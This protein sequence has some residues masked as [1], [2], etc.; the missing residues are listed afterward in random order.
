VSALYSQR[1][2]RAE[3][4]HDY[5]GTVTSCQLNRRLTA[6]TLTVRW[7]TA[8]R[9]A[10]ALRAVAQPQLRRVRVAPGCYETTARVKLVATGTFDAAV[11]AARLGRMVRSRL[12]ATLENFVLPSCVFGGATGSLSTIATSVSAGA[13]GTS[14]TELLRGDQL[15][16]IWGAND[17]LGAVAARGERSRVTFSESA[18]D[19]PT[20]TVS[21]TFGLTLTGGG[22]FTPASDLEHATLDF[23][24]PL[25]QGTLT[26]TAGIGCPPTIR[27]EDGTFTGTVT[28][29]DPVLGTVRF[30]GDVMSQGQLSVGGRRRQVRPGQLRGGVTPH[31]V[32]TAKGC[33]AA[34]RLG[35]SAAD[36][37]CS[38][39]MTKAR[40]ASKST[41]SS[42]APEVRSSRLTAAAKPV[43]FSFFF[44]DLGVMPARPS[45]RT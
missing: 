6:G 37:S 23:A 28:I 36:C 9:V 17:T 44:T 21:D 11:H 14:A 39:A 42:A 12:R 32:F 16:A 41:P 10:V 3:L 1:R 43:D 5:T 7:S 27:A 19:G 34:Q 4:F 22:G 45:G 15:E 35:I 13:S 8:L 30:S 40:C 29:D 31:G 26:F 18:D 38:A 24:S 33:P 2:G 20:P 25:S